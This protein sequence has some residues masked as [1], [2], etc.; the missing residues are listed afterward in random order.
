MESFVFSTLSKKWSPHQLGCLLSSL[1]VI[2]YAVPLAIGTTPDGHHSTLVATVATSVCLGFCCR[3]HQ[4]TDIRSTE[5][6]LGKKCTPPSP[7]S[8]RT[9]FSFGLAVVVVVAGE[10]YKGICR[11]VRRWLTSFLLSS[12]FC[13]CSVYV[14]H[15]VVRCEYVVDGFGRPATLHCLDGVTA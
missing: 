1:A 4:K 13:Y 9:L 14:F 11:F 12:S 8:S 3:K 15:C 5:A 6:V 7:P 2:W 10:I